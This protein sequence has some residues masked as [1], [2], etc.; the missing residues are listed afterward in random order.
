MGKYYAVVDFVRTLCSAPAA[1][2]VQD[3]WDGLQLGQII[4]Q[5]VRHACCVFLWCC[6]MSFVHDG[7]EHFLDRPMSV[8]C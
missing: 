5:V 4:A 8:N 1:R 3:R 6:V 2:S 7:A